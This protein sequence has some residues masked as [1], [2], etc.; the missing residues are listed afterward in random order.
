MEWTNPPLILWGPHENN[1]PEVMLSGERRRG[2]W[3]QR[4]LN[5]GESIGVSSSSQGLRSHINS[6]LMDLRATAPAYVVLGPHE[7]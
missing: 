2:K 3:D 4:A 5:G 6:L 1:P 7:T